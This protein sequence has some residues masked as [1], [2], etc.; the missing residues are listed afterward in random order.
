MGDRLCLG[1]C[2]CTLVALS[3]AS[4]FSLTKTPAEAGLATLQHYPCSA[5]TGRW[6]HWFEEMETGVSIALGKRLVSH[7]GYRPPGTFP[8]PCGPAVSWAGG[9][10]PSTQPI[11]G[12]RAHTSLISDLLICMISFWVLGTEPSCSVLP[13]SV[14]KG[15][16]VGLIPGN[17]PPRALLSK[18]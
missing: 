7:G 2:T 12:F 14:L 11:P 17:L 4:P 9:S 18:A 5:S 8:A 3:A 13:C 15:P 10:A 16:C 1:P 6:D